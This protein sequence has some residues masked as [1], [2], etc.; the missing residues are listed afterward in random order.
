MI[1]FAPISDK[2][3]VTELTMKAKR[4]FTL[5]GNVQKQP[6]PKIQQI[7]TYCF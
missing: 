3:T 6:N 1:T 5:D 7:A 4:I 2:K